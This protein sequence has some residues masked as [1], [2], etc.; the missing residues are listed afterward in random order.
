M[1]GPYAPG[2]HCLRIS[3]EGGGILCLT[4]THTVALQLFPPQVFT[5]IHQ[6]VR[7]GSALLTS[8]LDS[9]D[10]LRFPIKA[11]PSS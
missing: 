10:C 1:P 3:P 9:C 8:D 5:T 4:G 2:A 6:W 7:M 11:C